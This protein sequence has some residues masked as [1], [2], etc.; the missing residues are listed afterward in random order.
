MCGVSDWFDHVLQIMNDDETSHMQYIGIYLQW[1]SHD[2]C[3]YHTVSTSVNYVR[4]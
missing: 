1:Q 2:I 3:N 4:L